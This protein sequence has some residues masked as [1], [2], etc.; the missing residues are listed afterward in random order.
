MR[1]PQNDHRL[2]EMPPARE[3]SRRDGLPPEH[4]VTAE[5]VGAWPAD[6]RGGFPEGWNDVGGGQG[7]WRP[8][9]I[10]DAAVATRRPARDVIRCS[11]GTRPWAWTRANRVGGGT[12]S[13]PPGL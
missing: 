10:G 2:Q 5:A 3:L 9:G 6:H 12:R 1:S 11:R 4:A 8:S 13:G 7:P